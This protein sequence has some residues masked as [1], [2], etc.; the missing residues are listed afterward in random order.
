MDTSLMHN[1]GNNIIYE[2]FEWRLWATGAGLVK[3]WV[4]TLARF[5][6]YEAF[7]VHDRV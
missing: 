2:N 3:H 6:K 5:Y 4:K 1:A 7:Q